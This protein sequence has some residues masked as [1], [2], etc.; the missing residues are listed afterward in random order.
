VLDRA[1]L[2]AAVSVLAEEGVEAVTF[3]KVAERAGTT[4]PA[5]YRRYSTAA[6]LVI[7]AVRAVADQERTALTGDHLADLTAELTSFRNGVV[8][9]RSISLVGSMLVATADPRVVETY[10]ELIVRP[11]R[12]RITD[13]LRAARRDGELTVDV[14]DLDVVATFCTG[15]FYAA[16]LA[17]T[18]PGREW[19][20]RTAKLVWRAAGG[21]PR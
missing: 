14:H 11:R 13:I 8:R 1:I 3:A 10:R 7:A 5:L 16:S 9:L 18:T 12:A 2:D 21:R 19:P 15:S 4:R 17:G 6:D 20:R